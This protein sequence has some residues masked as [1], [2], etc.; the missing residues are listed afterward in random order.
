MSCTR[1][2]APPTTPRRCC[3]RSPNGPSREGGGSLWSFSRRIA[4]TRLVVID[5]REGRVLSN[6]RREM[7]DETEWGW[8]EQQLTGDYD[9]VVIASTL[10]VLLAPT[11]HYVEAWNEAAV[12]RSLGRARRPLVREAA[13]GPGPRALGRVSG[14]RFT[15]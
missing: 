15:A 11:L 8:L 13:P 12:R 9:H 2:S 10:P 3:A 5:G 7:L 1:R 4:G 14:P 6:G